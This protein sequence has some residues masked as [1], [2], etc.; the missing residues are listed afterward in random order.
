MVVLHNKQTLL[1]L[2]LLFLHRTGIRN[3]LSK[4]FNCVCVH[5]NS[6]I[7]VIREFNKP[8]SKER[9][10][11]VFLSFFFLFFGSTRY[12]Y[13]FISYLYGVEICM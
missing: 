10:V 7:T 4:F 5:E 9:Y 2:L 6:L 13:D 1:F 11:C 3:V 8:K 12:V